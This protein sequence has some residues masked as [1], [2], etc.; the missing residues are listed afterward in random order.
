LGVY[1]STLQEVEKLEQDTVYQALESA[2]VVFGIKED[3]VRSFTNSP[4]QEPVLVAEGIPAQPGID[5]YIELLFVN[6]MVD[7]VQAGDAQVD[8]RE[9]ST[10]VSTE[11]GTVLAVKHPS[12]PGI[13]GRGVTGELLLPPTPRGVELRAGKGVE[14]RDEGTKAVALVNGRPWAKETA[15]SC[16]VHVDPLLVHKND[17]NIKSGNIRF[18][19]DV[20]IMGNVSESMEV[21]ATGSIEVMGMVMRA[22]VTSG[23]K[24]FV[25]KGMINSRIKAGR[26]LP[27][28]EKISFLLQDLKNILEQVNGALGQLKVQESLGLGEADFGRVIMTLLDTKFRNIHPLVK[29]TMH[30]IAVLKNVQPPEELL[31]CGESLSC[32]VGLNPLTMKSFNDV[33]SDLSVALD[34][35]QQQKASPSD[36]T[37][38]SAMMSDIQSSGSVYVTSQGCVGTVIVAGGNVV[39][40]GPFRGG[41]I[42]C[43]GNVEVQELGSML[44]VPPVVRVGARKQVNVGKAYPGGVIQV[45]QR[46]LVIS[47]EMGSFKA[48]LNKEG[49]LDI[50]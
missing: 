3:V 43:E 26:H 16:V 48:R 45:G 4:C 25:R 49:E 20:K 14:I 13:E 46:R 21:S 33:H 23:G 19:G 50:I 18:K 42:F 36:V 22:A 10:I 27:G 28:T 39:I 12:R 11:A 35:L 31:K 5:E 41:E 2:G 8:F 47:Q 32:L 29:N 40:K 44:G 15:A 38:Y 6:N 30:Q 37:V 17:V 1:I 34:A 9:T 24:L 7:D